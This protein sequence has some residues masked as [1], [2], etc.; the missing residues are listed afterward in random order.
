MLKVTYVKNYPNKNLRTFQIMMLM[1]SMQPWFSAA[2]IVGPFTLWSTRCKFQF[3]CLAEA[4]Q[5]RNVKLITDLGVGR[6]F[7]RLIS[8]SFLF[9]LLKRD[10]IYLFL[11]F[12][13]RVQWY[14]YVFI[15]LVLGE[16]ENVWNISVLFRQN[17]SFLCYVSGCYLWIFVIFRIYVAGDC[18]YLK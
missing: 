6:N 15:R 9:N 5:K 2:I 16:S 13:N 7:V 10:Q 14:S 18:K 12:N 1:L 3:D 8:F 4:E 17:L 11:Y